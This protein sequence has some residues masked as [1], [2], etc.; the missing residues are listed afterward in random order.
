[1]GSVRFPREAA[2]ATNTD[3]E[4]GT[5]SSFA[6][7]SLQGER[8][9]NSPMLGGNRKTGKGHEMTN[10]HKL[11]KRAHKLGYRYITRWPVPTIGTEH[12]LEHKDGDRHFRS[13]D[14]VE[15]FVG[16][17]EIAKLERQTK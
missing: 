3:E 4:G 10:D 2:Q 5:R 1:M 7:P 17:Q 11:A 16:E 9:T 13:M 12:I 8:G 6:M 15:R 14:E